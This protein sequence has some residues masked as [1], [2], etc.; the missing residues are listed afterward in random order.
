[1]TASGIR[2]GLVGEII[3]A[4][5]DPVNTDLAV[6]KTLEGRV[7]QVQ[8]SEVSYCCCE[9]SDHSFRSASGLC[10]RSI[11]ILTNFYAKSSCSSVKLSTIYSV[12]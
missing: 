11:P 8:L 2:S 1:M 5:H 4:T 10:S 6:V 9:V 3:V 12:V 7:L